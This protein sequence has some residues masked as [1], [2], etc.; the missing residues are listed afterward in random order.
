MRK[1]LLLT[2][3]FIVGFLFRS[4]STTART[5]RFPAA[6]F[7]PS[8]RSSFP[9]PAHA[10][11]TAAPSEVTT[12]LIV[13]TVPRGTA[14]PTTSFLRTFSQQP[15]AA[16]EEDFVEPAEFAIAEDEL[17][18]EPTETESDMARGA[19]RGGGGGTS[20]T[21]KGGRGKKGTSAG[22]GGAGPSAKKKST[23]TTKGKGGGTPIGRR[24]GR[25]KGGEV[26]AGQRGKNAEELVEDVEIMAK[27]AGVELPKN[28][29]KEKKEVEEAIKKTSDRP[30]REYS[31]QGALQELKKTHKVAK[32]PIAKGDPWAQAERRSPRSKRG[33]NA[34][35]SEEEKKKPPTQRK[36]K[37]GQPSVMVS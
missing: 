11:Q 27:K 16:D 33:S 7:L 4:S 21:S 24:S 29:K 9:T 5:S 13:V 12:P 28:E 32:K 36:T 17:D 34:P 25:A 18:K 35:P 3:S 37:S 15:G 23:T 20:M 19:P 6:A 1:G 10:H 22:E 2:T 14:T 26:G 8:F 30:Y 31:K